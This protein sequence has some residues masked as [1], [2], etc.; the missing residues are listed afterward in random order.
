MGGSFETIPSKVA[1]I[2]LEGDKTQL[3]GKTPSLWF[4]PPSGK[5]IFVPALSSPVL[6]PQPA[7]GM[8]LH[9]F[10]PSELEKSQ[11]KPLPKGVFVI[12]QRVLEHSK[13]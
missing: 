11:D 5:F 12:Q 3:F 9:H 7:L 6:V 8:F 4:L 2:L 10:L 13:N 1:D